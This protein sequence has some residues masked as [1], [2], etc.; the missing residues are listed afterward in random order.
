MS[1]RKI[2]KLTKISLNKLPANCQEGQGAANAS[3]TITPLGASNKALSPVHDTRR[4]LNHP[5]RAGSLPRLWLQA[6]PVN[7]HKKVERANHSWKIMVEIGNQQRS[8]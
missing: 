4:I 3:L 2:L 8:A 1:K 5:A 7:L 6:E